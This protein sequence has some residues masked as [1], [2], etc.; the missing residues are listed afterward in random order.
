MNALAFSRASKVELGNTK[1][2][3]YYIMKWESKVTMSGESKHTI[4]FSW[5]FIINN[6]MVKS[7]R[8]LQERSCLINVINLLTQNSPNVFEHCSISSINKV[9]VLLEIPFLEKCSVSKLEG[10]VEVTEAK[11]FLNLSIQLLGHSNSMV[12]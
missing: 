1:L 4:S 7:L 2:M 10:I 5:K 3:I 9:F 12:A 8:I 6:I 11:A